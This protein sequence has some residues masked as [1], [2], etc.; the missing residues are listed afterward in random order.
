MEHRLPPILFVLTAAALAPIVGAATRRYGLSIVV[1]ELVLGIA[2]GPQGLGLVAAGEGMLAA[3]ARLGMAFLFFIAGM[4]IDLPAV[5]GRPLRVAFGGWASA[6]VLAVLIALGVRA[7]GLIQAWPVVAI[8]LV[9]TALGVLVPILRDAG[10]TETPLGRNVLASG[11]MGELGPILAMSLVLSRRYSVG[12]QIG[13]TLGFIVIVL[14]LARLLARGA[15]VPALLGPL[16]RGLDHSG[17]LP[18]RLALVLIVALAVL[19]ENAG[20]DLALGALTAGMMVGF[21]LRGGERVHDLHA[22]LDAVGF[23]FL[24]PVFFLMSGTKLDVRS[25][26]ARPE[27]LA[28]L[29]VFFLALVVVRLPLIWL[30]RAPLGGRG[31]G[32]VGLLSATTLSLVVVLTQVAVEAGA[33]PAAEAAS[34]VGAGMLGIVVF[35]ALGFRLA[36]ISPGQASDAE[37]HET[38]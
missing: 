13:L 31:A 19:A 30:L 11:V 35:P 4:E 37:A 7:A 14:V 20:L 9:T 3:L 26:V 1:I 28:L 24:V 33:M 25:M 23:G 12:A 27:G 10:T 36:G 2:I 29:A 22:K 16:R 8:A 32:A 15:K 38:L 6:L 5:R 34:M 18:I 21:A 17:Q